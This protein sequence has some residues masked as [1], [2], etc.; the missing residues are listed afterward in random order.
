MRVPFSKNKRVNAKNIVFSFEVAII[1]GPVTEKFMRENPKPPTRTIEIIGSQTLETLHDAIFD[2]FDRDDEH[3]YEFQFGGKK[4]MAKNVTRFGVNTDDDFGGFFP[5]EPQARDASKTSIASLNL[6]E[7]YIFF[8][9]FDFGDDWWHRVKLLSIH[10]LEL[11][12][13]E[14]PRVVAS[15]G[16]SPPQYVDWDEL[17]DDDFD[18]DSYATLSIEDVLKH[19]RYLQIQPLIA[20]FIQKHLSQEYLDIATKL[21]QEICGMLLPMDRSQPASWAA[22]VMHAIAIAN[23]LYDPANEHH[24]SQQSIAKHFGVSVSTLGNKG[25]IICEELGIFPFE[26]DFCT[27]QNLKNNPVLRLNQLKILTRKLQNLPK[28]EQED[29][30]KIGLLPFLDKNFIKKK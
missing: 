10:P 25:R 21:L 17:D 13:K 9:W 1:S 8:Y 11:P 2:A 12:K 4:P 19:P 18:D 28:E 6:D 26:P 7:G 30:L 5:E 20:E 14:F 29:A 3:L 22:G 27:P 23:F 16:E 24:I 15:S